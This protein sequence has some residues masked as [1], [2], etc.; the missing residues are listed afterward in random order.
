M[1][2]DGGI[3]KYDG[4]EFQPFKNENIQG[5]V[6]SLF[7]DSKDRIW[8]T[9]LAKR[10][11]FLKDDELFSFQHNLSNDPIDDIFE[12]ENQNY[13]FLHPE[14]VRVII[15]SDT[16]G[17]DI[18]H[19]PFKGR[20]LNGLKII[21]SIDKD[22]NIILSSKGVNHFKNYQYSFT[23]YDERTIPH[24][25]RG[26]PMF[27]TSYKDSMLV[28]NDHRIYSLSIDDH[29]LKPVYV[30][31]NHLL[32]AGINNL[33]TDVDDN[34][35]IAT[36][37][38][39]LYFQKQK[40]G[41]T[42]L[43]HLL[44]ENVTQN[45]FQD[46]EKNYWITTQRDGVFKLSST[47]IEIYQREK[48]GNKVATVNSFSK[49]E[50][51]IGYNNNWVSILN[52][53]L[54]PIFEKKVAVS[55]SEIYDVSIKKE[56]QEGYVISS[57]GGFKL[58]KAPYKLVET[59]SGT[60]LKTGVIG[61]NGD[62]WLGN[63]ERLVYYDKDKNRQTLIKE[64]T[65]A[66]CLGND[67]DAWIGTVA[68]LFY[69]KNLECKKI[70]NKAIEQ[71]IRDIQLAEDGTLWLA[72]QAN[73]IFLLNN[74]EVIKHITTKDNLSSNNCHKILLNKNFAWIATNNGISKINLSDFSI[75]TIRKDNGLPSNE[76]KDIHLVDNKIYVATNRGL[77]VFKEDY[78]I[79]NPIPALSISNFQIENQDTTL[80]SSYTLPYDKNN[81]KIIFNGVTFKNAKDIQYQYQ[82]KG[83]SDEWITSKIN[84]ASYPALPY[85]EYEFSLKAKTL[86]S[87]WSEMKKITFVIEKAFWQTWWF[88]LVTALLFFLLGAK[89]LQVVIN[90]MKNRNE[91]QQNLKDSQL[92]ALRAQMD[93]HFIFNALNS[94]QD[95]IIQED[96]RSA[97]HYLSKFSK[98]MRNILDASNKNKISLKKEIDYLKLYLSLEALRFE[99]KFQYFFEVDDKINIEST[100]VPS[101]LIQPY[102]EN[103]LKHGL[104]HLKEN[105][106]LYIRFFQK[107]NY[108]LCEIEDNGV[109]RDASIEINKRNEKVYRSR[110]MSLTKERID[111]LNT[112]ED[113]KLGLKIEDLKNEDGS[114][115]GTKVMIRI[116]Q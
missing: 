38:G 102:V 35:W 61:R 103:A 34:L 8:M 65:Y 80:Q 19:E 76:I 53:K 73:G 12:D 42:K 6:I 106:K 93:P 82:L 69:C 68:G 92:I 50:I 57:I 74:N 47:E 115:A 25:K 31:I 116:F 4:Q 88:Y 66:I 17:Q 109:G 72:T 16:L 51:V 5:E 48:Y 71:D 110:A 36:R 46:S 45:I 90:E 1:A 99:D 40:D 97:N 33:F 44:K 108:L 15:E 111:L 9:D 27:S 104:M 113:D 2:T 85:G 94:I 11:L 23:P 101:M 100:F 32:D 77:A 7:Y 39:V 89:V 55:N 43:I 95:F 24:P 105:K 63:F 3:C 49:N 87:D 10:L 26:F 58:N 114:A 37:D 78:K 60:G 18:N 22:H 29:I 81:I 30:E 84:E 21:S 67:D 28:A 79:F 112:A 91:I 75:K 96:K 52:E 64:R 20:M 83:L 59:Y 86:N 98:L 14:N 62:F 107:E 41:S 54:E 56:T 70:E 13:W